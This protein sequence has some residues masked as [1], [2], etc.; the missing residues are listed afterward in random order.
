M[1][2]L[3]NNQKELLF[4]NL[5]QQANASRQSNDYVNAEKLY[6]EALIHKADDIFVLASLGLLIYAYE[7]IDRD[8][9]AS[10]Y[11]LKVRDLAPELPEINL[12]LAYISK[13]SQQYIHA[14]KFFRNEINIRNKVNLPIP[15]EVYEYM[16][17]CHNEIGQV[18]EAI[19][20][21][22]PLID[23]YPLILSNYHDLVLLMAH[24]NKFDLKTIN[25]FAKLSYSQCLAKS[26]LFAYKDDI[27]KIVDTND[28]LN[29]SK[30]KVGIISSKMHSAYAERFLADMIERLDG[31]KFSFYS[32]YCGEKD[33]ELTD[34]YRNFSDKFVKILYHDF[35]TN[36]K[37]IAEDGV[38]ILID[39][40]GQ[41]SG[42]SL[43]V[44]VLKPAPVQ[45]SSIGYWGSTGL[46][47]VDYV[48]TQADSFTDDEQDSFNEKML[49]LSYTYYNVSRMKGEIK[50]SPVNRNGF[51]TFGCQNRRQKY[52]PEL[53]NTWAQIL[54]AVP[55]SRLL[56]TTNMGEEKAY[57]D[58]MHSFFT[59]QG[60]AKERV[61]IEYKTCT[62]DYFENY[63]RIDIVL[64]PYPF[65]GGCSSVDALYMGKPIIT[66]NGFKVVGRI[67]REHLK[68]VQAEELIA[69]D[70]EEYKMKA[71]E[72]SQN[73]DRITEYNSTF[74]QRLLNS[75]IIDPEFC[76]EEFEEAL[77]L[78][79]QEKFG[80]LPW[81][82]N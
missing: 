27:K 2:V 70:I 12:A 14:I 76:S 33:D 37:V 7:D 35:V 10:K 38:H 41:L 66:L 53:L 74:R 1:T 24:S 65:S 69:N 67:T 20:I 40:L 23:K 8:E 28:Y 16:A 49:R 46:P 57:T 22:Y 18:E 50:E 52:N 56:L 45:V 9:E 6:K 26:P 63:N 5:V 71:V 25:D 81:E 21:V 43:P 80:A 82:R 15:R 62:D 32:Y 60:V 4:Q 29:S 3:N 34:R 73:L 61:I 75:I 55:D 47:Q 17:S 78:M 64:D 31:E 77:E 79:Y 44:L 30:I 68:F 39:T 42:N 51:I 72:L 36:A 13:R 54:T 11:L 48:L 59:K 58:Y 19:Q